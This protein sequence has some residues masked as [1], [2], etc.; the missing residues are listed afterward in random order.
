MLAMF[1]LWQVQGGIARSYNWV[2]LGLSPVYVLRQLMLLVLMGLAYGFGLPTDA[3][4]AT[5][6]G[7][8]T[9]L[10]VGVGQLVILNRRLAGV[11]ESGPRAYAPRAWL[12][13]RRRSLW[14]RRSISCSAI[15]TLSSS[16]S[17]ARRTR[18]RSTTPRSRRWRWSPSSTIRWRKPSRTSSPNITSAGDQK[19]LAAFVKQS[20]RLTF[21]PSLA[22]IMLLLGSGG[23]CCGC[24]ARTSSSG[25]YLMFI[26][27]IGL[28]ARASVGPAERLL[29]MLGERRSCALVYGTFHSRSIS[30]SASCLSP[31]SGL[32][33]PR[34]QARSRWCLNRP[35]CSWSR[36]IAWGSTALFSAAQRIL[37]G[38]AMTI[39]AAADPALLVSLEDAAGAIAKARRATLADR[40]AANSFTVEWCALTALEPIVAEWRDLAAHALEP[41][42]FYE[43]AFLLAAAPVFGRDAGAMLVWSGRASRRLLGLFPGRIVKRRY[44]LKL[45]ILLGLTHPYGPLG[46]PLVEREA[47]EPVIAAFFAHLARLSDVAGIGIVAL[48]AGEWSLRR[49]ACSNAAACADAGRRL[50]SSP[51][52]AAGAQGRAV[53]LCR[54]CDR[55]APTKGTPAPVA[56]LGR[57][58]RR[59]DHYRHRARCRRR[60]A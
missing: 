53:A 43:P 44:G 32:P 15:P 60:G 10:C 41:N 58:R 17:I 40:Y 52:G 6:V 48:P 29:N 49:G 20:V 22:A 13:T 7:V 51:A 50:Q 45:P 56:T 24:T 35:V 14:S 23:R 25:Y 31:G 59:L 55:P 57:D 11:V 30:C 39:R 33:A 27:A 26:I 4:T 9:L 38:A 46:V 42:V 12:A 3:V 5:I 37:K 16:S 28:L 21:W 19:R 36:N 2:N 1:A 54:T 8:I 34:S 47:A 18:S